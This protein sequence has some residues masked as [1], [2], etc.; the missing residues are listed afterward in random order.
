MPSLPLL[1]E[2]LQD[3]PVPAGALPLPPVQEQL[4]GDKATTLN[5]GE[6]F[7][8]VRCC[9]TCRGKLTGRATNMEQLLASIYGN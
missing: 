3:L 7:M 2:G 8:Q 4:S 6:L 1:L 5:L 9:P